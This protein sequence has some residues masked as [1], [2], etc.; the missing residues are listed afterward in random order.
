MSRKKLGLDR[1]ARFLSR[2]SSL[3]KFHFSGGTGWN[4]VVAVTWLSQYA[5]TGAY[6][7]ARAELFK[8]LQSDPKNT[9]AP[10]QMDNLLLPGFLDNQN[11][12]YCQ[13]VECLFDAA[14]PA[15]FQILDALILP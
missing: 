1:K 6:D 10:G 15:D 2:E 5:E 7:K 13:V 11:A 8:L 4:K 3:L 12:I 9:K 14:G